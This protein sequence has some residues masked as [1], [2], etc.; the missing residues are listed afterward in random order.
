MEINFGRLLFHV[1]ERKR[2]MN[3]KNL[4]YKEGGNSGK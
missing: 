4:N 3:N 1:G 2:K